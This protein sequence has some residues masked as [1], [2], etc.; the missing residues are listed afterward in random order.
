MKY[1]L[2]GI[3]FFALLWFGTFVLLLK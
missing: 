2:M 1:A 3:S